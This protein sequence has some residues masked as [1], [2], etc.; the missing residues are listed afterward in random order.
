MTYSIMF[1]YNKDVSLS[2][3]TGVVLGNA[4]SMIELDVERERERERESVCVCVCVC[5]FQCMYVPSLS[6]EVVYIDLCL[7]SHWRP[8]MVAS[9]TLITPLVA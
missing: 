8:S 6:S 9:M 4:P 3:V 7:Y 1:I 5:V 2:M